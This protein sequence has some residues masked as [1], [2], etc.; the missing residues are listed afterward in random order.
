[1]SNQQPQPIIISNNVAAVA[2]GGRGVRHGMHLL[3]TI[4]TGGLWLPVWIIA[5]L[6]GGRGHKI[7]QG[8]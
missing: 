1:M 5:A 4:L 2:G 3:L 6:R 8:R 7:V